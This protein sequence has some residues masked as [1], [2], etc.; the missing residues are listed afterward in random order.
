MHIS[1]VISSSNIWPEAEAPRISTF[2]RC[3]STMHIPF[4]ISSINI[5]PEAA[6]K[7]CAVTRANSQTLIRLSIVCICVR[8]ARRQPHK[9]KN[10]NAAGVGR[11]KRK[12]PT[13]YYTC[14]PSHPGLN[15]I[16][17]IYLYMYIYI[18]IDLGFHPARK[19]RH[20]G[21]QQA[22]QIQT[23][24]WRHASVA[25]QHQHQHQAPGTRHKH[26]Q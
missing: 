10:C 23:V 3:R 17:F 26:Q 21:G 8:I 14:Y 22:F 13:I 2:V 4:G 25:C 1:F 15:Y 19:W 6:E 9:T 24:Q 18:Y 12:A 16:A 11:G 7:R 5:W 20:R